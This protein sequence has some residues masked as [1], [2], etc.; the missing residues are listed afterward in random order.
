MKISKCSDRS[1]LVPCELKNFEYQIEP[2][3]GCE[4]NCHYCYV[5]NLAETDWTKEILIHKDITSQLDEELEGIAPQ[6][7]YMGYFTDPYQP[8]EANLKQTR[9]VLELLLEK[10]FSASILTKSNLVERDIDLLQQMENA[11]VSVSVAF[12]DNC[13]RQKFEGNTIDTE[14]RVQALEKL[15]NAGVK[16]SALIC[17]VIPFITDVIS[18]IDMLQLFANTIW[19]Y[20]LS[21]LDRTEKN[22]QN[23]Q[24]ILNDEFPKKAD[25]IEEIIFKKDHEYWKELRKD[26]VEIQ[27]DNQLD[28]R[29]HL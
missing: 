20:G 22:W 15:K 5:L 19:I 9:K 6:T 2:Y 12:N 8:T 7:V 13:F 14:L 16:T 26:L 3:I 27:K 23:V 11:S 21:I 24:R 4:H 1:I 10:G 17:P 29:I 18:L 25:Q 28:L